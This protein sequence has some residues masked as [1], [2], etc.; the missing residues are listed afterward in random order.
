[1]VLDFG[2]GVRP[3]RPRCSRHT[4]IWPIATSLLRIV[5]LLAAKD[6][7][8]VVTATAFDFTRLTDCNPIALP[9]S[10]DKLLE[11]IAHLTWTLRP[12]PRAT[13]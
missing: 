5:T 13:R 3:A 4:P 1:M 7:R 12:A 10:A 8:P 2:I 11:K 9:L 6:R